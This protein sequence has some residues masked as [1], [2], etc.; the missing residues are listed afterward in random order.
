MTTTDKLRTPEAARE[1]LRNFTSRSLDVIAAEYRVAREEYKQA[2]KAHEDGERRL[3]EAKDAA[4]LRA[5]ALFRELTSAA[6]GLTT[7]QESE[8]WQKCGFN[9]P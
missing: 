3:R 7:E 6:R 1:P 2:V 9:V 4:Q 5:V 8:E